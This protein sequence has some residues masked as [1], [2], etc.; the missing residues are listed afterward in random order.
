MR[1]VIN[2][3]IGLIFIIGGLTGNLS[4]R[5]TSSGPALALVGVGLIGFGIYRAMNKG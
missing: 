3:V 2:I 5:G 1:G 4:L